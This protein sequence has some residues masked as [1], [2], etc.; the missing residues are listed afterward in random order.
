MSRQLQQVAHG[1]GSVY[2]VFDNEHAAGPAAAGTRGDPLFPSQRCALEGNIEGE[3]RPTAHSFAACLN[4]PSV[5][6]DDSF[7]QGEPEAQTS[8]RPIKAPV[9]LHERL[10]QTRQQLSGDT[11]AG[12]ADGDYGPA[13]F[14]G[15]DRMDRIGRRGR[16]GRR[17]QAVLIQ[18]IQ[19]IPVNFPAVVHCQAH[20]NAP[21]RVSKLGGILQQVAQ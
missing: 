14:T 4:A 18:S 8:L 17:F 3:R 9:G 6:L 12:I 15:I 21:A 2:V 19:S 20:A 10:K 7:H 13:E 1:V 5:E 16:I 11:D